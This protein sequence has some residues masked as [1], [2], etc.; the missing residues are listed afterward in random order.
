MP[1]RHGLTPVGLASLHALE[2][3]ATMQQGRTNPTP[4]R[5]SARTGARDCPHAPEA[6]L[7]ATR[8]RL[9]RSGLATQP[10]TTRSLRDRFDAPEV[11]ASGSVPAQLRQ[12]VFSAQA[13][14]GA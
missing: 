6:T 9:P 14:L 3:P 5:R 12:A 1:A 11:P 7:Q 4:R 13:T 2:W 8:M 10:S